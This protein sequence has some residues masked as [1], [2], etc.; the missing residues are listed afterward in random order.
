MNG[1]RSL[2]VDDAARIDSLDALRGVAVLGILAAI[3]VPNFVRARAQ[4]Q[5]TACQ[6]NLK[7]IGTA[8]EMYSTDNMGRYPQD[9]AALSGDYLRTIPTCPA[10]GRN[11]Y[12]E[13][14]E[15]RYHPEEHQVY[16]F[17]CSGV[18]HDAV[19]AGPG[20]PQY[21]STQGLIAK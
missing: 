12:G 9:L 20:Y 6:S 15:S 1:T 5:F 4:G 18:N 11:N 17:V 7:N 2:P 10:A 16:A 14:Y 21:T 19:G 13:G 3:F 8:L